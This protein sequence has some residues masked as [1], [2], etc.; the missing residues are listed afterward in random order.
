MWNLKKQKNKNKKQKT[1]KKNFDCID[2]VTT[3]RSSRRGRGLLIFFVHPYRNGCNFS[4]NQK[5]ATHAKLNNFYIIINVNIC[6]LNIH[7]LSARDGCW[8]LVS[9]WR[10][11]YEYINVCPFDCK[12]VSGSGKVRP[13]NLRFTTQVGWLVSL[14]LT[15]LS[16]SLIV[17]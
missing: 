5:R 9:I 17:V 3:K 11:L 15:V 14:Q 10:F 13:L 2:A 12:A 16:R 8:S 1:K 7:D 6:I 4:A